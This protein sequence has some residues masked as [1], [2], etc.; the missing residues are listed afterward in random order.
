MCRGFPGHESTCCAQPGN[1]VSVGFDRSDGVERRATPGRVTG[2]VDDVLHADQ[3][4]VEGSAVATGGQLGIGLRCFGEQPVG[5][6][7]DEAVE[8]VAAGGF[9]SEEA[10]GEAGSRDRSGAERSGEFGDGPR[11]ARAEGLWNVDVISAD[12]RAETAVHVESQFDVGD[13]F[14]WIE[15]SARQT[16]GCESFND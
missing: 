6:D 5:V 14:V 2:H 11:Q 12:Q 1:H 7:H 10:F 8:P 9:G 15:R 16:F 3:H 4:T 13:D